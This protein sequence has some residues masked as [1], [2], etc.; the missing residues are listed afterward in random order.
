MS[1][2]PPCPAQIINQTAP[3]L[4]PDHCDEE[5]EDDDDQVGDDDA[6]GDEV[7]DDDGLAGGEAWM[8]PGAGGAIIR[9][10]V[11]CS[12]WLYTWLA[13]YTVYVLFTLIY[14]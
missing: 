12:I 6:V 14:V 11:C 9:Q 7:G 3:T 8:E 2:H 1:W 10:S 13:L 5:N 4:Y